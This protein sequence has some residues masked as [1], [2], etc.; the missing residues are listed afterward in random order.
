M[1]VRADTALNLDG[2]RPQ[3]GNWRKVLVEGRKGRQQSEQRLGR[4]RLDDEPLTLFA[5]DCVLTRKLELAGNS[6]SLVSAVPEKLHVAFD[7]H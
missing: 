1:L 7:G 4:A 2:F 5:H 3:I 6:Y